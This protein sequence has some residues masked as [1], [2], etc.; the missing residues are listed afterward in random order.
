M[1]ELLGDR[2]HGNYNWLIWKY[3]NE[4]NPQIFFFDLNLRYS[5]AAQEAINLIPGYCG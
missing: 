5:C 2:F 1:L 3:I 4:V